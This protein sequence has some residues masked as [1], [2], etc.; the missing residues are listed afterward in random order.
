MR[1]YNVAVFQSLQSTVRTEPWEVIE[2]FIISCDPIM[3]LKVL[4][5]PVC[6]Q[7]S[8]GSASGDVDMIEYFDHWW[9]NYEM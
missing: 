9:L 6:D 1:G 2:R 4:F 8:V 3:P 5:Q 7:I